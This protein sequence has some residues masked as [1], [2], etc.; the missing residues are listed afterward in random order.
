MYGKV[1]G[2][3]LR[4]EIS[5]PV[6]IRADEKVLIQPIYRLTQGLSV[7][8]VRT[9]MRQALNIMKESPFETLPAEIR[10][11]YSLIPLA[12]ALEDIHFP[13]SDC[14]GIEGWTPVCIC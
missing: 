4:R 2:N 14:Y 11:N 12:Q 5:S 1:T 9:N 13:P 7:N 3:L 10:K 8:M 6:Y